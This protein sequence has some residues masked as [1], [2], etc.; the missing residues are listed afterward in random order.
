MRD[1]SIIAYI[2][3]FWLK[4]NEP[5]HLASLLWIRFEICAEIKNITQI[6]FYLVRYCPGSEF[7]TKAT[8]YDITMPPYIARMSTLWHYLRTIINTDPVIYWSSVEIHNN[9]RVPNSSLSICCTTKLE[10]WEGRS[11]RSVLWTQIDVF[12]LQLVAK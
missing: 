8:K 12:Y 2:L 4:K 11:W 5:M 6:S 3:Y 1:W 10:F 9:K 7:H